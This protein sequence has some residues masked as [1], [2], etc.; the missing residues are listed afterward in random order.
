MVEKLIGMA[1]IRKPKSTYAAL[2]KWCKYRIIHIQ[3][4]NPVQ[5]SVTKR[6]SHCFFEFI[7]NR[8]AIQGRQARINS[9]TKR[10]NATEQLSFNKA[11]RD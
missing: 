7:P 9:R 10:S 8:I 1:G 4:K 5:R 2:G 6:S 11:A 3:V